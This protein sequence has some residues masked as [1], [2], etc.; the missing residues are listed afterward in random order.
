MIV[1]LVILLAGLII[2][3]L[4]KKIRIPFVTS[5]IIIGAVLGPNGLGYVQTNPIIEFFGFLGMAFLMFMAGLDTNLGM[6][7]ELRYKVIMMAGMNMAVPFAFGLAIARFFGYPWFISFLVG[8]IFISSSAIASVPV[9]EN[10]GIIRRK[11]GQ[12][13]LSSVIIADITSLILLSFSLQEVSRITSLPLPLYFAILLIS[14]VL[15]FIF[16]PKIF[17]YL[18]KRRFRSKT[19][20]EK[21]LR[22]VIVLIIGVLIFFSL[23]GAHPIL[24]AFIIGMILSRASVSEGIMSKFHTLGY[25]LFILSFSS[26]LECRWISQSL[27]SWARE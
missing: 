27:G 8:V 19:Y 11:L 14:L 12:A 22:F 23:L 1:L 26:Y 24:A 5:L 6:I 16:I 2:P 9:L 20:Y 21:Q 15:M 10:A 25:G 3:E 18:V 7:K 4:F 13:I 17:E